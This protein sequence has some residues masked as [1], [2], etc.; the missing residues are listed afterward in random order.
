MTPKSDIEAV[1]LHSLDALRG[2]AALSVVFWHWQHFFYRGTYLVDF[3]LGR[4]PW[5]SLLYPFYT[6]GGYAVNLFFSISGFVF[7]LL[8]RERIRSRN[9]SFGKF[10]ILRF[11]RLY[12]LHALT[13]VGV[14]IGQWL[15]HKTNGTYFVYSYND[16]YHFALQ[17]LMASD[18]GLERGWSFNGPVWSVS[19]EVLCYGIFFL[20][21]YVGFCKWW[22][23]VI[24]VFMGYLLQKVG[25]VQVGRGIF[26]FFVGGLALEIFYCLVRMRLSTK[27][28]IVL[29][30]ATL[31]LWILIP[32]NY[33]YDGLSRIYEA[34]VSALDAERPTLKAMGP[35]LAK[36]SPLLFDLL[37]FPATIVTLALWDVHRNVRIPVFTFLGKISYSSY[38]LHFPL[39]L[40]FVFFTQIFSINPDFFYS[41]VSLLLFF[42]TLIPLSYFSYQYFELPCQKGI[43]KIFLR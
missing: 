20:I 2:C 34:T 23:A 32:L 31:L 27:S 30:S 40:I 16:P 5:F 1:H 37:L 13:L 21:C 15:F 29:S 17:S 26:C 39:Q 38:L 22:H 36:I 4:Q 33:K 9:T 42:V 41:P 12:P 6:A 19:V 8:Y 35:L 7:F 25:I 14:S 10:W 18:W 28:L 43:R 24:L 3:D 11:S